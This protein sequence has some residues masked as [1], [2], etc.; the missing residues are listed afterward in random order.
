M[1]NQNFN[2][3][4]GSPRLDMCS[5]CI[6]LKERI[7]LEKDPEKKQNTIVERAIHK[8][9]AK[10]FFDCLKENEPEVLSISFDCQKNLPMPKIPTKKCITEDKSTCIT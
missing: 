4:F 1:F 9:R 6:E 5:L 7:K 3:G 10:A 2:I 8:K